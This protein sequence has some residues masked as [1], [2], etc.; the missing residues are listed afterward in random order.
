MNGNDTTAPS[1]P[2]GAKPLIRRRVTTMLAVVV[3]LLALGAAPLAS[4]ASA[5]PGQGALAGVWSSIDTDGSHQTLMIMG[6]GN[7]NYAAYYED[8]FTSAVCGGPP[9][10]LVGRALA[11]EDGLLVRGTLVCLHSGNPFPREH[12]VLFY[13]YDAAADTLTDESGVVWTR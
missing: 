7:P 5:A 1:R 6:A 4:P 10:K 8:D 9:A 13:E 3:G 2:Q 11:V 12:I